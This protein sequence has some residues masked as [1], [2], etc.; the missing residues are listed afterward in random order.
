MAIE[1]G[2]VGKL[3]RKEFEAELAPLQ[4]ELVALQEWVVSHGARVCVLFEGRDA[5]G[6]GGAIRYLTQR[7]SP[8]VFRVVALPAPSERERSQIYMQRYVP[9]L[10]A[11]GEVVIFDRSWYNRAGVEAVMGF[12]TPAEVEQFLTDTPTLEHAFVDDG[13]VLIK[14]WL[15]VGPDEQTRRFERRIA[16]PRRRWKL[17]PMDFESHRRWYDYS[18]ARDEMIRR[19]HTPWA[20]WT[21][22][23][24]RRQAARPAQRHLRPARP[25]ALRAAAPGRVLAAQAPAAQG[26]RRARP[27]LRA[28]PRGALRHTGGRV[29]CGAMR[30][31]PGAH[32][33]GGS[34]WRAG[35]AMAAAALLALLAAALW[36]PSRSAAAEPPAAEVALAREYA[37]V[38]RLKEQ[39]GSC[40]IGQPYLP[41]DIN[42]L[43]GNDE[44]ALRGPWDTTSIVKVAPT[45][46][47]LARGLFDYHL[48]FPGDALRPGCTYEEW[49]ARLAAASRPTTYARSVTQAGVPGRLALQYWFFYVFNDWNNTHEGDWEMI[50]LNFDADT[51][52]QA[53]TRRPVEVGYSQHSSAE[54][55]RWGDDKLQLVD[56]THPVVY[57]AAGSQ[58]NFFQSKLYLMRSTAEGLGCDDTTGPSRTIRPVVATV[59]TAPADYLPAFPWLGFDGRWGEKQASFFNGPVG[60]NRSLRWTEPFT[61]ERESWRNESF[62]VPAGTTVGTQ[63]TDF[64]CGAVAGG[65]AL[66]RAIKINPGRAALVLA[67]LVLLLLWPL[68][69]TRW[70]PSSVLTLAR[71]RRWGQLITTAG[72]S[73]ARRPRVFLGIGLLF[74]PIGLLVTLLQWLL[75]RVTALAPLVDE[76]G[77]RNAWVGILA[78]AL[79]LV[80]T[81]LGLAVVQAATARALVEIEAGRRV[82]ALSAYRSVFRHPRRLLVAL[83]TVV[84]VQVVLDLT[85]VLIPVAIFLL[86]RWSLLGAVVGAEGDPE[87]GLLRRSAALT[88]GHWWRTASVVLGVV[89]LA[90]LAGPALGVLVLLFTGAAFDL[91]NLIA[92]LVYV[93]ALPFAA[94]VVTYLYFDLR[95][96]QETAA[97]RPATEGLVSA[98]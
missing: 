23:R 92:A 22:V 7:V 35:V 10:P 30:S 38:V 72:R 1:D 61:W 91:V 77:E 39:P 2:D 68:T 34:A 83:A 94:I 97:E 96:R 6:K 87:V 51:P 71:G 67:A 56:G 24:V 54:R 9:Y 8:R 65:S 27:L 40:G 42:V 46:A 74:I 12:C 59:P 29:S 93:A 98:T 5:A 85:V 26:L 57:P 11:A 14:Y 78:F 64:F 52:A 76:A 66:L 25:A 81:L 53:L 49:E 36:A 75:F 18:R 82:T 4:G 69:R 32:L 13:I 3:K 58:A 48:D 41:T 73:F 80:F 89:G 44:V 62:S 19:T 45:A 20:P 63:A 47:D 84:V 50:Q 28:H 43:M 37:P 86:V 70:Q 95:V 21:I 31:T 60:P 90:L 79:G 33:R 88:R 55:A 17:S 15:E 16:D